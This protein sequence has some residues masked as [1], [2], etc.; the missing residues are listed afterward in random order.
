M[1]VV[2]S[3]NDHAGSGGLNHLKFPSSLES[4]LER[5]SGECI[6]TLSMIHTNQWRL[7]CSSAHPLT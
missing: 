1:A 5:V 2:F 4:N 3:D 7:K 6:T